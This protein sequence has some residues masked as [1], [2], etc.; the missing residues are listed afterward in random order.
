MGFLTPCQQ[1]LNNHFWILRSALRAINIKTEVGTLHIR[2]LYC[3]QWKLIQQKE[4]SGRI[5]RI[6]RVKEKNKRQKE[7]GRAQ[8]LGLFC[9]T[10]VFRGSRLGQMSLSSV[11]L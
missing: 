5:R 9:G 1:I 2:V 11:L 10:N 8:D 3:Q 6:H 4:I 7:E